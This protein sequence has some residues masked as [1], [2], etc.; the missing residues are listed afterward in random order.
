MVKYF[1]RE[2]R[3]NMKYS[4][5][6]GRI[7]ITVK[8]FV[9]IARR[10]ISPTLPFDENEPT[11][12][13]ATALRI[14][15]SIAGLKS[16]IIKH[17]FSL[18]DY[19]FTLEGEIKPDEL[20]RVTVARGVSSSPNRPRREEVAE[21]RG[22]GY[23]S[24][25]V[26][27]LVNG[28]SK[29]DI[30]FIY[31]D[32]RNGDEAEKLETV[33]I[34]KLEYFFNKCKLQLSVYA[35]PEIERVT[36]RLPSMRKMKFP[37][38][39]IRAGQS[40]FIR[41]AYRTLARGGKLYATAP[42]GTGKTVSALY[43]ALRSLGERRCEKV[44]YF[45]PKTTT[46]EAAKECLELMVEK[47]A[48]IKAIILTAKEKCC[49]KNHLCRRSKKLCEYAKCNN[50]ANATL[51]LYNKNITVVTLSDIRKIAVEYSV[52]PYELSLSYSELCDAVICD[53]NYLFDPSVYIRRFFSTSGKYAFL[54]DE[55]H[56]LSERVRDG[57]SEEIS[58]SFLSS[59]EKEDILG[60]L[61]LSKKASK[62]AGWVLNNLLFPY[63]KEEL[64]ETRDGEIIGA[65][66]LSDIPGRLYT[67][68]DELMNVLE[69]EIYANQRSK[70]DEAEA[71]LIVLR[72]YY[73]K[74]KNFASI[75]ARFDSSYKMFI[76]YERGEIRV[77][78]FCLD[79]GPI[80]K[81]KL[82]L[83]HGAVLFSATLSPLD[84][85]RSILGGE[86]SD[87]MLEVNSPFDPSQLS[88][89]IMNKIS[90]RYSEREDTLFAVVRAIAAAI[91]ARRGNYMIFS[92]SFAYSE[93]LFDVFKR[94]YPKLNVIMQKKD[95][96]ERE[97]ADFLDKFKEQ[98]SSY[99]VGFC[100]M[101]GIYSEGVDLAGESLIGAIIVG[102]GIP[103]LSYEREAI[104]EYFAE[105]YEKGKEYAYIYPGMNR[106]FQAAGRVIR[107]EEDRGIIVLID[108]RFDDPIYKK[109]LPKLWEG[110]KFIGDARELR[111][112]LD[113]FWHSADKG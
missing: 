92:P 10:G 95:M 31:V 12:S 11:Q 107:R 101:G 71:R 18:D 85:Y 19:D 110:V 80:I 4:E 6:T 14:C 104:Q 77:K 27:A 22:E 7:H 91:S 64:R 100:V 3:V 55:A 89:T 87:E 38:K 99:L 105:K 72:G 5:K 41:T 57:Y 45:T 35:A 46:A 56:N 83:G 51:H 61:S 53:F 70:D 30:R 58:E 75:L 24:A 28:L 60:E 74:I 79:T 67:L 84:Y 113:E 49:T 44:F 93:A 2:R 50:I 32:I 65:A 29:V 73:Y 15:R 36:V 54:I 94:K 86:R 66:H 43:P 17:D 16:E 48:K 88:V 82:D 109:S 37:Y 106:V 47:G 39:I 96:T 8:E 21:I 103:S 90:T 9:S 1:K 102:I 34:K 68:F 26:Y 63:V 62:S 97:K 81:E 33:D 20:S 78:L 112:E 13:E 69:E 52:C 25:Y 111:E 76:F 40:E 59:L 23:L 42:T 98:D 108:D